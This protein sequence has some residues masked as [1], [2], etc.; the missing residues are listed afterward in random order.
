MPFPPPGDLPDPEIEPV[1]PAWQVDSL[2]PS[3]LENPSAPHE[4]QLS[5]QEDGGAFWD[6][7]ELTMLGSSFTVE[8][9]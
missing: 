8:Q 7:R 6:S 3:L 1:S 5:K 4:S 2:P 9:V